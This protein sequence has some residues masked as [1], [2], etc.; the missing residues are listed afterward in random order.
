[1][2]MPRRDT[3]KPCVRGH[4][5]NRSAKDGRCLTCRSEDNASRREDPSVR[6]AGR[7]YTR[8]RL[9]G[10]DRAE[11]LKRALR[12][13]NAKYA[14]DLVFR[15]AMKAKSAALKKR[16]RTS[17]AYLAQEAMY[18]KRYRARPEIRFRVSEY[19]KRWRRSNRAKRNANQRARDAAKLCQMPTWL[20]AD[21]LNDIA[22][23]YRESH[24]LSNQ[25]GI[26]HHVDHIVPLRGRG[27]RGLHVPW[28]L[29]ILTAAENISKGNRFGQV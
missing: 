2:P 3:S 20:T 25:T 22:E 13:Q 9:S 8:A 23:I 14:R 15:E 11:I 27:V 6:E 4:A 24:R 12:S 7:A 16:S 17:E 21:H 10:P 19:D 26:S 29:Q 1:M 28:N 18:R 5:P